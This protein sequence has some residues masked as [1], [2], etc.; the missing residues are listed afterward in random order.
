MSSSE[1][2][3]CPSSKPT[4]CCSSSE[5][6]IEY[7]WVAD[8][9]WRRTRQTDGS[10]PLIKPS[11]PSRGAVIK[12]DLDGTEVFRLR[13]PPVDIYKSSHYAPTQVAVDEHRFGG[14]GDIW[15]ADGYGAEL[16]HDSTPRVPT[17]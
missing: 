5:E 12:Y 4:G 15:V 2:G 17:S 8:N 3:R 14:K 7:L 11:E 13:V 9:G 10:Y 1:R 16:V 6:G